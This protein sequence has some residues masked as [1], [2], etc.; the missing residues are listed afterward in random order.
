[1]V[2]RALIFGASGALGS[3]IVAHFG[4]IGIETRCVG[5]EAGRGGNWSTISTD[6]SISDLG[7]QQFNRVIWA[8][9]ANA[10]GGLSDNLSADLHN[11]FT[12]NVDFIVVTLNQLI[13]EQALA[14]NAR[15]CV[16]SSVWQDLARAD[17]V[18]YATTKAAVG[19]L[20]RSLA[21]ELGASGIAINAILPG[22]IDTP[23]TRKF[24]NSESIDR[25]RR[26][27]AIPSLATPSDIARNVEWITG[28]S[29][30]GI[31]GQSIYVDQGWSIK[32][33]V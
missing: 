30:H 26:D 20:V 21:V 10:S 9:G 13:R 1:M 27:S 18:A 29:S 23:M 17:K 19:G 6:F 5:R 14:Q 15:L 12:I 7:P 32:R 11:L 22:V 3:E 28:P 4:A 8:Q 33:H 25:I 16:L 2:D 31:T 24:L